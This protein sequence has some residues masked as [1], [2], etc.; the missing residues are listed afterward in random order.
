MLS[1]MHHPSLPFDNNQ[2]KRDIRLVKIQQKIS[3][4]FRSDEGARWFCRSREYIS[5]VKKNIQ[6][7]LVSLVGARRRGLRQKT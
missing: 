3:R 5:T 7:V 1:F 4:T 6:P 2:A